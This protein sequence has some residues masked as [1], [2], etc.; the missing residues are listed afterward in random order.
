MMMAS[1]TLPRRAGNDPADYGRHR[2]GSA[3]VIALPAAASWAREAIEAE[4]TLHDWASSGPESASFAGRGEVYSFQ[5]P[6]DGP[7]RRKR[8]AVRHYRRGGAVA[9]RLGD[10]YL[11]LGRS[12]PEREIHAASAARARGIRTPAV[13]AG[14]V[15]PAG[16]YY[17][18]DLA[19]EVVTGASTLADVARDTDG[20]RAWLDAMAAAGRLATELAGA[21]ILHVDFNAHNILFEE[22]DTG[23]PWVIDLDRARVSN[24]RDSDAAER[25]LARLTRSV[26]KVG[27]PTGESLGDGEVLVALRGKA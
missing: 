21:G 24:R 16:M 22:G 15:Y 19:T 14:A 7:D 25:M 6:A 18:C 5:A 10:R 26:V 12:R 1:P 23:R 9:A 20:T 17:R 13:V 27:T 8:W 2:F 4:G 11:R 3:R